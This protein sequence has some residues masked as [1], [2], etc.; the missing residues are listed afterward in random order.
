MKPF[1]NV[2][3]L[4]VRFRIGRERHKSEAVILVFDE[5]FVNDDQWHKVS[6][7]YSLVGIG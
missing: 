4:Q 6:A 5:P 1:T 7:L 3:R 2:F